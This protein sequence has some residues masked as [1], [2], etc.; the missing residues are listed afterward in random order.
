MDTALDVLL[1]VAVLVLWVG[2]ALF[3]GF[4]FAHGPGARLVHS[5]RRRFHGDPSAGGASL[6]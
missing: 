6:A 3:L 5:L 1:T 4:C 2:P